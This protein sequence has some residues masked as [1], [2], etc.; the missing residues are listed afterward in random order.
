MQDN[1]I[2]TAA[3]PTALLLVVL[4][5]GGDSSRSTCSV[6][7]STHVLKQRA[8]QHWVRPP[9]REAEG[10]VQCESGA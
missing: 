10:A 4:L 6:C 3:W 7:I 1:S 2:M 8:G 9:V 5:K